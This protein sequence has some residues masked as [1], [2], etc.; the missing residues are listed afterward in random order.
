MT[1][2]PAASPTDTPAGASGLLKAKTALAEARRAGL[3]DGEKDE[4]VTFRAPKALVHA[5]RMRSGAKGKTE[6][7]L[8]ALSLAA[9][10]DPLTDFLLETQGVLGADHDLE[11]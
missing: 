9:Q 6:L 11:F 8:I 2:K 1:A 7:G 3:L 10:Q 4:H 5:A